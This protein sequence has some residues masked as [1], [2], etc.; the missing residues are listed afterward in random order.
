VVDLPISCTYDFDVVSTKYMA[1][2]EDGEI[3]LLFLFSGT[4]FY[5]GAQEQLQVEQIPWS[6]EASYRLPVV[7]W[8]EMMDRYYPNTAWLHLR[9]DMFERLYEYKLRSGLSA[10]EDVFA[11]LLLASEKEVWT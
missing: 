9:R 4:I 5:A 11:Q 2:L 10:W 7:N 3:P 1:A 8:Q 6:T